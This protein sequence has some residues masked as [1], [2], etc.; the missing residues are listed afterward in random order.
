VE[1][2]AGALSCPDCFKQPLFAASALAFQASLNAIS[3]MLTANW[4]VSCYSLIANVDEEDT[5]LF[6]LRSSFIRANLF[7]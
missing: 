4:L 3:D 6:Q 2:F 5:R 1:L 7:D